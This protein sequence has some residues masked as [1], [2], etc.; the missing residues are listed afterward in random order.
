[1]E[2]FCDRNCICP[3]D[4]GF[5]STFDYQRVSIDCIGKLGQKKFIVRNICLNTNQ[6]ELFEYLAYLWSYTH[7][8][9]FSHRIFL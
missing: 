6:K 8:T 3:I 5:M 2:Q 1:M 4:L 7:L 9:C